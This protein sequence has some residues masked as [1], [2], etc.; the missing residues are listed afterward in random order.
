MP[1]PL[2]VSWVVLNACAPQAAPVADLPVPAADW[3]PPASD[4][5]TPERTCTALATPFQEADRGL[6]PTLRARVRSGFG[7]H[8]ASYKAG[9]KHAGVDLAT[10]YGEVVYPICAG[11]VVDV[12]LASPH[13]TVVVA[14]VTPEGERFWSTYK[15]V[16]GLRVWPGRWVDADTPLARVFT[17]EEQDGVGW[18]LNHLHL[19]IRHSMA[20]GGAASWTSMSLEELQRYA[21]DPLDFFAGRMP[22]PG[23][24]AL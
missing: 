18:G 11:R 5:V 8:R 7:E 19:E 21:L 3:V 4:R 2:L 9:H 6:M 22:D 16:E 14:H 1:A 20:D 23:A 24:D 12:H 17:E 10:R 15:H 13:R